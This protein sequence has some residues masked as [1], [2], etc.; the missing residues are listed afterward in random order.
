MTKKEKEHYK[1]MLLNEK[2]EVLKEIMESDE[3]SRDLL[4]K[5]HDAC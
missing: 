5:R 1:N 3:T 4:G 2:D